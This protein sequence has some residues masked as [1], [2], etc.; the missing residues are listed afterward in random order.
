MQAAKLDEPQIPSPQQPQ[1]AGQAI[2]AQSSNKTTDRI[3]TARTVPYYF[4]AIAGL[5]YAVG[6]LVE[7]TFM[8][9]LGVKDSMTEP[10]KAKH[11][12]IGCLCLQFPVSV[13]VIVLLVAKLKRTVAK[14]GSEEEKKTLSAYLP[15]TLLLLTLLFAFYLLIG[16]AR[17][18]TFSDHRDAIAFFF[19]IAVLGIFSIAELERKVNESG[20]VRTMETLREWGIT[21][22]VW[23]KARWALWAISLVLLV[24]IFFDLWGLLWEMFKNAGYLYFGVLALAGVWIWRVDA[25]SE[26]LKATRPEMLMPMAIICVT[27]V[28]ALMYLA[29]LFFSARVYCYIPAF[30]GGGDF[31]TESPTLFRFDERFTN[32]ISPDILDVRMPCVSKPLMV[33]QQ[34]GTA[35]FVTTTSSTNNPTTWR[36]LGREFKPRTIY[37]IRRDAVVETSYLYDR[38]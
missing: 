29:V 7:F 30:K 23:L 2:A 11:I 35:F 3:N 27:V 13:M 12:Y 20:K 19:G 22:N 28:A 6:F 38:E 21:S 32:S 36:K 9:S 17:P 31:T 16:F 18:Y 10:F 4:A 33:L 5:V 24:Y 37:S 26:D 34:S 1:D 15:G 8:N 25:R 14:K